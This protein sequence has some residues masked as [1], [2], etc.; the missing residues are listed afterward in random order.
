MQ[1]YIVLTVFFLFLHFYTKNRYYFVFNRYIFS[2]D[3][4]FITFSFVACFLI[5]SLRSTNVGTDTEMYSRIYYNICENV[6][7]LDA[8]RSAPFT[9]PIYV[10][11]SW[12]SGRIWYDYR[13]FLVFSSLVICLGYYFYVLKTSPNY[14]FSL[15]SFFGL[16][17]FYSSMNGHRQFMAI[18]IAINGFYYL[19]TSIKSFKGWLL[20]FVACGIHIVS[21]FSIFLVLWMS[22]LKKIDILNIIIAI[23]LIG[24]LF[25]NFFVP[26]GAS[27]IANIFPH[28]EMYLSGTSVFNILHGSGNGRIVILYFFLLSI[29]LL[30]TL[31]SRKSILDDSFN[32]AI[33]SVLVFSVFWGIINCKNELIN[34]LL[35][36]PLSLFL[37]YI[38]SSIQ[39]YK[40][41]YRVMYIIYIIFAL[42][43]YSMVSLIENQNGVVPYEFYF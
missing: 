18:A 30:P 31:F 7:F 24:S 36:F 10:L 39:M 9:A 8:N 1:I 13:F 33:F 41:K 37:S 19:F 22:L 43:I 40:G 17:I 6:S 34:R 38:P 27:I 28:Y 21:L 25:I 15:I 20:L 29:L 16:C 5:M 35:Y 11:F 4:I 3:K 26:I 14:F 2:G 12:I 23:G 32:K 42:L